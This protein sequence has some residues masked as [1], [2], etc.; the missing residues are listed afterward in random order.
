MAFMVSVA[1]LFAASGA[2]AQTNPSPSPQSD[3]E[4]NQL[5]ILMDTD[6]SG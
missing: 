1:M 2:I 5:L 4:V 6:K 3:A